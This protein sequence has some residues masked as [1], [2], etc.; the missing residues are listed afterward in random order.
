MFDSLKQLIISHKL[1][2]V[3]E[4]L[5][6]AGTSLETLLR[7]PDILEL[8]DKDM[9]WELV[10]GVD[11]SLH[12]LEQTV[13]RSLQRSDEVDIKV[14]KALRDAQ[15]AVVS[16]RQTIDDFKPFVE[17]FYGMPPAGAQWRIEPPTATTDE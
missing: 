6:R 3:K 2:S 10:N 15:M 7:D 17:K 11:T 8:L 5:Q 9:A 14:T 16:L 13:R 4:E 12:V 1:N